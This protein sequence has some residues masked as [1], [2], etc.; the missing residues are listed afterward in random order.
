MNKKDYLLFADGFSIF[1]GWIDFIVILTIATFKF[2]INPFEISILSAA[3]LLP[4][5][6]LVGV[7]GK[8]S[9]SNKAIEEH[10]TLQRFGSIMENVYKGL[11]KK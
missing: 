7:I 1:G 4:S 11:V 10:F 2:S 3:M 5:I 9:N 8:V 6:V